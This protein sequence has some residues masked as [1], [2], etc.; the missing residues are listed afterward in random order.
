MYAPSPIRCATALSLAGHAAL[1][2]IFG[3]R[4]FVPGDVQSVPTLTLTI[5]TDNGRDTEQQSAPRSSGAVQP[6]PEEKAIT[7]V[8]ANQ[9]PAEIN[10]DEDTGKSDPA[11]PAPASGEEDSAA[12]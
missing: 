9:R 2:L 10:P 4:L 6:V 7:P 11:P 12:L 1:F 5:A 8:V 3:A